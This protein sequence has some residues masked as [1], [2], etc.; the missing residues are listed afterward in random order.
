MVQIHSPRPTF[1]PFLLSGLRVHPYFAFE[2]RAPLTYDKGQLYDFTAH[3]ACSGSLERGNRLL[4]EELAEQSSGR[5]GNRARDAKAIGFLI[6]QVHHHLESMRR[7]RLS[8]EVGERGRKAGF[9][10]LDFHQEPG[11]AVTND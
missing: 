1:S 5:N 3:D 4:L 11:L 10:N 8:L 2:L 6:R 9:F 7:L